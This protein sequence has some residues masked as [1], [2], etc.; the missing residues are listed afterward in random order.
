MSSTL[1]DN[2]IYALGDLNGVYPQ[3]MRYGSSAY[4]K[5]GENVSAAASVQGSDL[6]GTKLWW[7]KQ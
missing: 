3:R 1:N 7:A 4:N 5:N 2:D 6:Q